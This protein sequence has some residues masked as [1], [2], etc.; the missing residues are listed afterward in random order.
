MRHLQIKYLLCALSVALFLSAS[1][2]IAL[3]EGTQPP[4]TIT[5]N[6]VVKKVSTENFEVYG[7]ALKVYQAKENIQFARMN[8]LPKLNLW[9]VA[10]V[11]VE[12]ALGNYS[13]ALGLIGDI[14]PFLVPANWFRLEAS[15]VLYMAEKEGYRAFWANSLMTA[16]AIYVHLLLDQSLLEHIRQSEQEL[17][18]LLVLVT[19]RETLGGVPQGA[20][21]DIEIRLLGLQED[22]RALEVLVNEEESLLS[23]YDGL[24]SDDSGA[25]QKHSY[26]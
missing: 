21:R 9:R 1:S 20:S 15:K 17:T 18:D 2:G 19:S 26:A 16:K 25:A 8:L 7:N 14:A 24:C 10:G 3:A 5:I 23:Y 13:S 4:V 6:D 11:A 12:S 22:E